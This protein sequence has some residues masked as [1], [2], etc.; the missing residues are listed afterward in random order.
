V[1]N[2][3]ECVTFTVEEG[4]ARLTINRPDVLNAL[5]RR[6]LDEIDRAVGCVEADE[7][8]RG[9]II[10]GAGE[11]AF[12]AG[13]DINQME[14]FDA[15]QGR[16]WCL[17]GQRIF[18]RIE[19]LGVP[20]IAAVNG[21]AL[22]GG[23]ELALACH[24]RIASENAKLGQPEVKLGVF[25]GWGGTQRLPRLVGQG[26]ALEFILSG[27]FI[28]A[29]EAWRIG[30]VNRVVPLERLMEETEGLMR[31]I[32][33]N[34]PMAVSLA[35]SAVRRGMNTTLEE[36][37]NIEADLVGYTFASEDVQEGFNAFLEKRPPRF[38]GR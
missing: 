19:A 31:D 23:C 10:T 1:S 17:M 37:Q 5:N 2:D 22:G 30:L 28:D 32:L 20:V 12:V 16:E 25:P 11:R 4:I 21:Y 36:G 3:F 15:F 18:N 27:N 34:G 33:A 14:G 24:M 8:A 6:T 13:A 9:L 29:R 35:L 26:R 38:K 7:Q